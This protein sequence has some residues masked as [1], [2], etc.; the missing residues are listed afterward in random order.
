MTLPFLYPIVDVR[1][2]ASPME[3]LEQLLR[4]GVS[5]AQIRAKNLL[6]PE[7]AALV[8]EAR[9][10][11]DRLS[12]DCRLIV[13]DSPSVA[14]SAEAD[15]VHLGQEDCSPAEAREILGPK[16][17]IGLSTH[18]VEQAE[19]APAELLDYIGFGPIFH[20]DTKSGH[21]PETGVE[22]LRAVR[23]L[24]VLPVVAIGGITAEN[25]E[26]VYRA[27]ASSVAVISDLQRAPST[28]QRIEDYRQAFRRASVI[29]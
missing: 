1:P 24:S 12:S 28:A 26:H 15:G 7:L 27:G 8:K 23:D 29:D 10:V 2:G 13:N 17:I 16:A 19:R 25:A 14:R 5:I 18:T 6:E 22:Q 20:S 21:A 9:H 4:A 3:Q 11:R